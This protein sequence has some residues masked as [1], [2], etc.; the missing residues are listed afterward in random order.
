MTLL[1]VTTESAT[2]P[3]YADDHLLGF[4]GPKAEAEQIKHRLA[5]FLHDDLKLELSAGKTLITSARSQAARFLGYEITAHHDN[6]RG[7]RDRRWTDGFIKLNVPRSV[8]KAK[9]AQYTRRGKPAH[10]SDLVNQDDYTIVATF[11]AQ[12]RGLVQYYLLAGNAYWLNRL[13]LVMQGSMLRTLAMK[14]RSSVTT[15]A[16]RHKAKIGTPYGLRTCS[17]RRSNG[18]AGHHWSRG[19]EG[20]PLR[21]NRNA[22]PFDRIP[23][24]HPAPSPRAR[25]TALA[26]SMRAL[27]TA[28]QHPGPPDPQARRPR[29]NGSGRTARVD[30]FHGQETPQDARRLRLLPRRHPYRDHAHVITD[31]VAGEPGAGKP[32]CPVRREAERKR[33]SPSWHLAARPTLHPDVPSPARPR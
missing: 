19:S 26:W 32:A 12:Y 14:H 1:T 24:P 30:G 7:T 31:T 25:P 29:R 13:E 28:G 33:T 5:E 2:E 20:I 10:R 9:T 21:R 3:R 17:K 27:R 8:I 18:P 6:S 16:A 15:M 23:D 11:G 22:V 4:T